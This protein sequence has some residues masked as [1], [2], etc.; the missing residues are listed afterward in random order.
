MESETYQNLILCQ[1]LEEL[2]IRCAENLCDSEVNALKKLKKLKTLELIFP[3]ISSNGFS[4]LFDN[5]N[6]ENLEK[7]KLND[8]FN[9]YINYKGT[10]IN[11]VG[12]NNFELKREIDLF[13]V[14]KPL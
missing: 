11:Y 6:L 12:M 10:F 3:N 8:S 9:D 2:G 1:N 14:K 5:M 4:T 7:L 13:F